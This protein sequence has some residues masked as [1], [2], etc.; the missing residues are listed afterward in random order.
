MKK[1]KR[2]R[3]AKMKKMGHTSQKIVKNTVLTP[4]TDAP[5][6][7]DMPNTDAFLE[8]KVNAKY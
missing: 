1:N 7:D 5:N 6:T 3:I 8:K 4:N 2:K